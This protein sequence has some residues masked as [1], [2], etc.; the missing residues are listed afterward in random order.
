VGGADEYTGNAVANGEF[1]PL[2]MRSDWRPSDA[3][4]PRDAK[5]SRSDMP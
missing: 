3:S 5:I 1:Q 2:F 4:T